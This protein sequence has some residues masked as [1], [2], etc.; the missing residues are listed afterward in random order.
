[1]FF[2]YEWGN[3]GFLSY[4]RS[5]FLCERGYSQ[6]RKI[7]VLKG[8]FSRVS[9]VILEE[10]IK[11]YN[12]FSFLCVGRGYSMGQPVIIYNDVFPIRVGDYSIKYGWVILTNTF[13]RAS[14][15]IP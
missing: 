12:D 8:S 10:I 4:P 15:V 13:P 6:V 2:P 1:M 14:G 5:V 7:R 3:I 9:G 11:A